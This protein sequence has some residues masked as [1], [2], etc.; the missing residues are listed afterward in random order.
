MADEVNN[1]DYCYLLV[2]NVI[3]SNVIISYSIIKNMLKILL[4]IR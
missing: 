1:N 3:S 4:K 2:L